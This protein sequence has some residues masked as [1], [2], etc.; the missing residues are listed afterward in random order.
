MNVARLK[1]SIRQ[2]DGFRCTQCG[3]TNDQHREQH[4]RQ[5]D[6]HRLVPGSEYKPEGCI[7][8]CKACHRSLPR[9]QHGDTDF[10]GAHEQHRIALHPK[11]VESLERLAARNGR[12]LREET[13]V[14]IEE[15]LARNG[16]WPPTAD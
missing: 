8:V 15:H 16:L 4:N 7:T 14:A 2:R 5:L 1:N 12:T 11:L 10:Y 13:L 3:M 6:V 9:R